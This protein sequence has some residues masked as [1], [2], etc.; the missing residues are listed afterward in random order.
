MAAV[1]HLLATTVA[2]PDLWGHVR[3]GE[4]TWRAKAVP[5]HDVYSYTTGDH[6]W[7]N[8]EWLSG[9]LFY[10]VFA[11]TGSRGLAALKLALALALGAWIYW[12]LWLDGLPPRRAGIVLIA[13]TLGLAPGLV[14]LRPQVFTFFLFWALLLVLRRAEAGSPRALWLLPPMFALWPN[15]HG[16]VLV[17]LAVLAAWTVAHV[18]GALLEG[19]RTLAGPA[20]VGWP[21]LRPGAV[22]LPSLVSAAAL[23]VNPWGPWLLWLLSDPATVSRPE[24]TEWQPLRLL[25][26]E[27]LAYLLLAG[28]GGAGLLWSRRP[29]SPALVLV[30]I[31]A[32][33]GPFTATRHLN[34]FA[35]AVAALAGPHLADAWARLD[36]AADPPAAGGDGSGRRAGS[37]LVLASAVAALGLV[38][39]AAPRLACVRLDPRLGGDYPAAAVALLRES[40]VAANL[41]I[42]FDWGEYAIWHVGPRVKVSIDGR[43]DSIYSLAVYRENWDFKTGT[44]R[45]DALL[46]TRDTHLAL[47]RR[48]SAP[49]NLLRLRPGWT[50]LH[51]DPVSALH[52]RAGLAATER[53]RGR[54]APPLPPDGA[55]LCF[56]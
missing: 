16:G 47:V 26:L 27:G 49:D 37:V 35:L 42:D 28:L 17:G 9:T 10:L 15:L 46:T 40:G 43:R 50:L 4:D 13:V 14:T 25:S 18:A 55:G 19:R 5:R 29:R 20:A 48:A 24:I 54:R 32:A 1:A 56:P 22:L 21:P 34:L 44:G 41:A 45:W 52:G 31:G 33:L 12:R 39:T 51:E 6:P 11:G 36:A 53:V 30:L 7:I 38:T 2:D 8:H 23:L 3:F